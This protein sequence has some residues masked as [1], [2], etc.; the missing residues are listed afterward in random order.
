MLQPFFSDPAVEDL[1]LH[2]HN[3]FPQPSQQTKSAFETKTSAINVTPSPNAR[4]DI[5]EIKEDALWLCVEAKIDEI[6]ALR[7]VVQEYQSRAFSGLLGR[8]SNQEI[9]GIQEAGGQTA[10]PGTL[11]LRGA[12]TEDIIAEFDTQESRRLRILRAF[13]LE[14]PFL[15]KCVN[16]LLQNYI[17][18]YPGNTDNSKEKEKVTPPITI[19]ALGQTIA[20]S[21]GESD[22]W[23]L[24]S[25]DTIKSSIEKV[26]GG[27][28]WYKELGGRLDIETD[29]TNAHITVATHAMETIFQ[30]LDIS[31]EIPSSHAVLAWLRLAKV[32][33]FFQ[34][35]SVSKHANCGFANI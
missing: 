6:S 13:L 35:P 15:L 21:I 8:L 27:S 31:Q 22:R 33:N 5:K 18:R 16:Y 12:D 2:P 17:H 14:R 26:A 23:L 32:F 4:F 30:I 24:A 20:R 9:I 11:L 25:V 10:L 7:V 29:W 3:A 1:L 28:G 19:E 34:C